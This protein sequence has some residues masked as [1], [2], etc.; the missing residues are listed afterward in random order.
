MVEQVY[1]ITLVLKAT[2]KTIKERIYKLVNKLN[3]P[4]QLT[5]SDARLSSGSLEGNVDRP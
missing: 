1:F 5:T 3:E 2:L 4:G